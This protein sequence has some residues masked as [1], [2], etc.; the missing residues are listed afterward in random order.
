MAGSDSR[1]ERLLVKASNHAVYS[2]MA[3]G[4][5]SGQRIRRMIKLATRKRMTASMR[6]ATVRRES[7]AGGMGPSLRKM[8]SST[9]WGLDGLGVSS[10]PDGL[11]SVMQFVR[12][13]R[14][15]RCFA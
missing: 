1:L 15:C 13:G 8:E 7:R 3:P 14:L 9:L 4:W 10:G 5:A 11:C 6:K 2:A 12:R